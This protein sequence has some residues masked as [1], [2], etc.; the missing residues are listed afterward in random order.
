MW[1]HLIVT[2]NNVAKLRRWLE[3]LEGQE[4]QE[5]P[6]LFHPAIFHLHAFLVILL[7]R[8][9]VAQFLD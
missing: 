8:D 3:G 4:G 9:S 5:E 7:A 1:N 6:V 2:C